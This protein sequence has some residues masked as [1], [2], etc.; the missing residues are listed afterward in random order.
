M[1]PRPLALWHLD[2]NHKLI[3]WCF[4]VHGCLDGYTCIPLF[5]KCSNNNKALN[6]LN[7]FRQAVDDWGLPSRVRCDKGGENVDVVLYI[8]DHPMCRPGRGS[9][10]TGRSVHNERIEH[11]WQDVYQGVLKSVLFIGR[12][13]KS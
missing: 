9:A 2:G 11:L 7:V 8:L 1:F 4:V 6:V 3:C 13:W 12:S 5:L 10:I